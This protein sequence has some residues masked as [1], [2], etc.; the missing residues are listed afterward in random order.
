M[1]DCNTF[2]CSTQ[3]SAG[4]QVARELHFD[5]S[6]HSLSSAQHDFLRAMGLQTTRQGQQPK[7]SRRAAGI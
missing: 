1:A 7:V 3:K 5:E 2:N 6:I 4:G